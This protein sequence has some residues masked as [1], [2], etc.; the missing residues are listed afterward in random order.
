M[1]ATHLRFWW[2][3]SSLNFC[4]FGLLSPSSDPEQLP[5]SATSESFSPSCTTR[6]KVLLHMELDKMSHRA[7]RKYL[8]RCSSEKK[9]HLFYALNFLDNF[10]FSTI[11]PNWDCTGSWNLST[12][13]LRTC[14]SCTVANDLRVVSLMFCELF[15]RISRK[16]TMPEITFIVRISS[17]NFVHVPKAW[18]WAHVQSFSVKFS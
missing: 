10:A 9:R 18:L 3:S 5:S 7:D 13:K 11:S 15:K 16:Y 17:W 14:L 6:V 2:K 8:S 1:R 4:F 12:Q